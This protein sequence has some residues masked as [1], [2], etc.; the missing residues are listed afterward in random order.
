MN[1]RYRYLTQIKDTVHGTRGYYQGLCSYNDTMYTVVLKGQ[2][3]DVP[4]SSIQPA[5]VYEFTRTS[6]GKLL[7]AVEMDHW[8]TIYN[9]DGDEDYVKCLDGNNDEYISSNLGHHYVMKKREQEHDTTS[10]Q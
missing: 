10:T 5:N 9:D 2:Q 7:V 1:Y 6:D 4:A 8:T 3:V